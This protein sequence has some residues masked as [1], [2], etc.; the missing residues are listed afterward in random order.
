M[1]V[2]PTKRYYRAYKRYEKNIIQWIM[3]MIVLKQY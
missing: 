3:L 1:Q 2:N